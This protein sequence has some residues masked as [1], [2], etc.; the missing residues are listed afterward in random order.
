MNDKEYELIMKIAK[1]AKELGGN[2]F[3][4]NPIG[5]MMDIEA[6][7]EAVG[8][9]LERLANARDADFVHDVAGIAKQLNRT[10]RQLEKY[11]LPRIAIV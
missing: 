2:P 3:F 4:G 5:T 6:A 11:F 9:D 7:H 10:P 1:R 8:I